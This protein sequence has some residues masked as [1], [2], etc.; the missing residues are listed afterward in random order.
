MFSVAW[1]Y[2]IFQWLKDFIKSYQDS[3]KLNKMITPSEYYD[4]RWIDE[5]LYNHGNQTC[6]P[7]SIKKI[8][9]SEKLTPDVIE[10]LQKLNSIV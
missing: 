6:S 2:V 5:E 9:L 7:E 1:T 8:K 10:L 4:R 3:E